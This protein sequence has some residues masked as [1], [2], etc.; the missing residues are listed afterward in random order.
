M[1]PKAAYRRLR[2]LFPRARIIRPGE[3]CPAPYR[4]MRDRHPE[5]FLIPL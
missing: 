4:A 5:A 3:P 2:E 1:T